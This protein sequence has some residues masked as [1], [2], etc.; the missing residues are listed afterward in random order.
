VF[1]LQHKH[2]WLGQAEMWWHRAQDEIS[3]HFEACG[4]LPAGTA[5]A[6]RQVDAKAHL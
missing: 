2:Y 4:S 1:D 5:A 3:S 6:A